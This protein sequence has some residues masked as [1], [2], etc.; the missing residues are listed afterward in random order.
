[1][2]MVIKTAAMTGLALSLATATVAA[3][4]NNPIFGGAKV[5]TM[6]PGDNAKVAGKGAYANYYG[7]YG[8]YYAYQSWL[9]A[10]YGRYVYAS[11][12]SS[13]T[14]SYLYAYYYNTLATNNLYYA[15]YYSYIG[16]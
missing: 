13:E 12:S 15:Y 14:N 8:E 16:Q 9:N 3:Q 10:Y 1:M 5:T 2:K 4:N 7:Y 6:S 11:N